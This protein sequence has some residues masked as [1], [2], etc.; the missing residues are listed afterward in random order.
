MLTEKCNVP[1]SKVADIDKTLSALPH[2]HVTAVKVFVDGEEDIK[3]GDMV[4]IQVFVVLTRPCHAEA[5]SVPLLGL[6]AAQAHTPRFPHVV[7]EKWCVQRC[8]PWPLA[9]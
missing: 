3:E 7:K 6:A 8:K 4:T 9:P 2:I 1:L 5:A